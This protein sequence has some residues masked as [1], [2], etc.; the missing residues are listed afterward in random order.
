VKKPTAINWAEMDENDEDRM[1]QML[2]PDSFDDKSA[3]ATK[4][5]A[6]RDGL[7]VTPRSS[8]K[9]ITVEELLDTPT[10]KETDVCFK[11]PLSG[12]R[13]TRSG[14]RRSSRHQ[15]HQQQ[16]SA[17]TRTPAEME[18][19]MDVLKRRQKDLDYG[20]NTIGYQNYVDQVPK[21]QRTRYQPVTPDKF[22]KMPRRSWDNL[23]KMWR[24]QLHQYDPTDGEDQETEL[25]DILS[26]M[27][28]DSKITFGDFSP[29]SS[30]FPPSSPVSFLTFDEC[31]PL[32]SEGNLTD[33]DYDPAQ[34]KEGDLLA[35]MDEA[36]FL[37]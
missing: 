3:T 20:K 32:S 16:R 36:D 31:P 29:A 10:V 26:D 23:I 9:K 19:Q 27:S 30:A 1:W 2:T 28:F 21:H 6:E 25:S 14:S 34:D 37:S 35:D 15:Q 4:S 22:R 5:S 13:V 33:P 12:S 11:A 17:A 18:S 7:P 8:Y 24:R